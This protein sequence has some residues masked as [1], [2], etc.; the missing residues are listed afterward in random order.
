MQYVLVFGIHH[1]LYSVQHNALYITRANLRRETHRNRNHREAL[2]DSIR[3]IFLCCSLLDSHWLR[4]EAAGNST[5]A[6]QRANAV[7]CSVH[8]LEEIMCRVESSREL[9]E[10]IGYLQRSSSSSTNVLFLCSACACACAV[11]CS[12]IW[13]VIWAAAATAA[14]AFLSPTFARGVASRVAFGNLRK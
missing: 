10:R 1:T 13:R 11:V 9:S 3:A 14:A 2:F 12:R 8:I 7:Q 5:C 6:A 4:A